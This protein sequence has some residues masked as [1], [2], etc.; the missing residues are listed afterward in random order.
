MEAI[1]RNG[2]ALRGEATRTAL[3]QAAIEIF[4][5]D[6]YAAATTKAIAQRAE[7][8]QALISYYF[9]GKEGL[10]AAAIG[11]IADRIAERLLPLARRM[12]SERRALDAADPPP[13]S[14]AYLAPLFRLIDG[15]VD[16]LTAPESAAWAKV[17]IREQQ[18]PSAGFEVVY[19][20]VQLRVLE[21]MAAFV[22]RARGRRR[23]SG[24]DK[25]TVLTIVG[26]V[27]VFRVARAAAQ[28]YMGWETLR[29]RDVARIKRTVRQNVAAMLRVSSE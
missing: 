17:I 6:G 3:I 25:L 11:H 18:E 20:R 2:P 19:E 9:G 4:G 28:R 16:I 26:Q 29:P 1:T 14:D 27:L 23:P 10:Y 5:R 15:F 8:N 7:A 21:R 22:A 24:A 12:E 13:R